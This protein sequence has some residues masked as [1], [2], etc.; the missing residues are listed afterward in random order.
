MSYVENLSKRKKKKKKKLFT[1]WKYL[2]QCFFHSCAFSSLLHLGWNFSSP[3]KNHIS[4]RQTVVIF[5]HFTA[6]YVWTGAKYEAMSW[7]LISVEILPTS[8]SEQANIHAL[9]LLTTRVSKRKWSFGRTKHVLCLKNR[10]HVRPGPRVHMIKSVLSLWKIIPVCAEKS[11]RS[12][13]VK[14]SL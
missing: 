5:Q 7:N 8:W 14:I 1:R 13:R 12:A 11:A 6:K 3:L 4:L 10:K 2:R 9:R